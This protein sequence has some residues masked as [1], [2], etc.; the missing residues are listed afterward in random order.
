M[1]NLEKKKFET[2]VMTRTAIVAALYVVLT[3]VVAPIAFGMVQFR[4]SEI[5]VL[6]AF[7][8]KRYS[9]GLILGCFIANCFSPLGIYDIV[10]GTIAT[11]F[12]VGGII[13]IRKIF[14]S[15]LK[16]LVLA[17][18]SPVLFNGIIVGTELTL[19]F[20]EMPFILNAL[21]VA[22]GEFVVITIV[23]VV[24]MSKIGHRFEML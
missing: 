4:I 17:S 19:I 12:S 15:N 24:I 9:W 5:M 13:M 6:L 10:F 22:L 14:G 7:Y 3:L 11:A 8:D 16:S 18:F 23:G 2:K 21:Y 1:E 20:K